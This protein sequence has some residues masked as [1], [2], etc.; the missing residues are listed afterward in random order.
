MEKLIYQ[1]S[2]MFNL[3]PWNAEDMPPELLE[4]LQNLSP[5]HAL[6]IGCGT[7]AYSH[8]LA[9]QGWQVTGIDFVENAIRQARKRAKMLDLDIDFRVGDITKLATMQLP[10]YKLVLD[11]KCSH[12]LSDDDRASYIDALWSVMQPDSLLLL[13]TVHPRSE[14][15]YSFGL[16]AD[17][18]A[19]TYAQRFTLEH[20][21]QNDFSGWYWLRKA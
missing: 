21:K 9:R 7:G 3:T 2:Y 10:P 20:S 17:D 15:G 1:L 18:V 19:S 11:I 6:D 14:M 5:A 12:S 13:E 8:Y 16:T 4:T